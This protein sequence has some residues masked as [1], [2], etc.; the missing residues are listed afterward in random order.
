MYAAVSR[1]A[2]GVVALLE[3]HAGTFTRLLPRQQAAYLR[4]GSLRRY[5]AQL[6]RAPSW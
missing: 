5:V 2:T 1:L 6:V 3:S 4:D